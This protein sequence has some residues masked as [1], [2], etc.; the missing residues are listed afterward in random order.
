MKQAIE[1]VLT[2]SHQPDEFIILDDCSTDN[3]LEIIHFYAQRH[4][5]IKVLQNDQNCGAL[6]SMEKVVKQVTCDYIVGLAADDF[7]LPEYLEHGMRLAQRYPDAGVIMGQMLVIDENKNVL[8]I[9]GIDSWKS[10]LYASPKIFLS[11]YL[12]ISPPNHSLSG[13]TIYKRTA[14]EEVGY[15]NK[16]LGP[17]CD[18]FAIRAIALKYG[19][20]YIPTPLICWRY[21]PSSVSNSAAKTAETYS[22]VIDKAVVLMRSPEFCDRFPEDH[23]ASWSKRYKE[24][25]VDL[26]SKEKMKEL[27]Q[28]KNIVNNYL[29]SMRE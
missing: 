19:A 14:F 5:T 29:I 1:S 16:S 26:H 7:W 25:L 9:E 24:F 3:S 15:Y 8:G 4:P 6:A 28:Y 21:L 11:E 2:Q 20:C 10:E 27:A 12:D 23:V 13:A 17:W 18:T 22:N